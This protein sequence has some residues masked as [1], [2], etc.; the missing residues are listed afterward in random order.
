M[1]YVLLSLLLLSIKAFKLTWWSS[2][3]P[4]MVSF[5]ILLLFILYSY[6]FF[7]G[8]IGDDDDVT[9]PVVGMFSFFIKNV[10]IPSFLKY[11][12]NYTPCYI[13]SLHFFC[14]LFFKCKLLGVNTLPPGKYNY[15]APPKNASQVINNKM[16]I[17]IIIINH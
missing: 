17:I 16:M 7:T 2:S 13:L 1:Y 9:Y 4:L 11:I 6:C 8:I 15:G 3:L 14:F 10:N 5:F 12:F